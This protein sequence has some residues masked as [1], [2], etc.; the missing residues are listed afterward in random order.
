MTFSLPGIKGG[1]WNSYQNKLQHQVRGGANF[2]K[3][4]KVFM[5]R[6][7]DSELHRVGI[8]SEHGQTETRGLTHWLAIIG[9][10]VLRILVMPPPM[11]CGTAHYILLCTSVWG[12]G[13]CSHPCLLHN[14]CELHL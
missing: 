11:Q 1:A 13:Q 9:D 12:G 2:S 8:A 3:A 10:G 14:S 4:G 5:R 6:P 7:F